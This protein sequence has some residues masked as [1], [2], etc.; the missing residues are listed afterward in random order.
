[1][2]DK[3]R[4]AIVQSVLAG[5]LAERVVQKLL[6]RQKRALVVYTG[7]NMS[8]EPGLDHLRARREDGFN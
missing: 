6:E 3:E 4:Y 5:E 7:S 8:D 1:M 2:T